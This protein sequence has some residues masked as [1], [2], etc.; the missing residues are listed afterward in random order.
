MIK[1]YHSVTL[2]FLIFIS[3][4]V[5][6]QYENRIPGTS[7]NISHFN[8]K[9]QPAQIANGNG[10]I[11]TSYTT[12]ACG[13]NFTQASVRLNQ[14]VF[15]ISP[16]TGVVQPATYSISGIP[17]CAVIVKAFLYVGVSGV[18]SGFGASVTNPVSTTSVFPMSIIGAHID[19][20]WGYAGTY[21]YRADVTSII[22]GNGNYVISG[23]PVGPGND[24][25]GATLFVIYSDPTQNY[26]G[27]I[28]IAD[29]CYVS[30]GSPVSATISG[31]NVCSTPSLTTNFMLVGDLQ[32]NNASS[33]QLN[34]SAYNFSYPAAS[35]NIWDFIQAP[36]AAA[37]S[38]QTSAVYGINTTSDCYSFVA[39]GMYY[40]TSCNICIAPSLSISTAVSSSCTVGSATATPTGGT[41]PYT[42]TWSPTGGNASTITGA[43]TGIYTVTVKDASCSVGTATIAISASPTVAVSNNTIC[44]GSTTTLLAT[45]ATT[46]SW[47]TG[48]TTSQIVVSPTATTIYTITGA[49]GPCTDTKTVSITVSTAPVVNATTS[50]SFICAGQ[51]V[52]LSATGAVSYTYNP[53]GITGNPIALNPTSS[54][55]YTVLGS[56]GSCEGFALITQSVSACTGISQSP[57][58]SLLFG[59]YPNPNKGEFVLS[60]TNLSETNVVE[61]YNG[62]GQLVKKQIVKETTNKISIDDQPDGVYYLRII[63]NEN[64][65]YR[66]RIIKE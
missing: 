9:L 17:S 5:F 45:G 58:N 18:G 29:G 11:T 6:S 61:I 39:A 15:S 22:S 25:D 28:V 53:G 13:L 59:V 32:R 47:S 36:G 44:S 42:Y 21:S 7:N 33:I 55:T 19:K 56:N 60:L 62:I 40:R 57:L 27:S 8:Y 66:T 30:I 35:Q 24:A 31:F 37:V 49:N 20:C 26:T 12:S 64:Q 16:A 3:G 4:S 43:A 14:R 50:N 34:S 2:F 51:T 23:I 38:G 54:V 1:F 52:T 63:Q 10:T 41:G 65:V 46:Y 48:A